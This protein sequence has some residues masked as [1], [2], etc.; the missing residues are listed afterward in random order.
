MI[1]QFPYTANE[2]LTVEQGKVWDTTQLEPKVGH[3]QL[4]LL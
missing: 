3:Q 4:G 2:Q 1:K